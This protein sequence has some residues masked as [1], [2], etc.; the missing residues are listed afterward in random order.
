MKFC[1]IGVGGIGSRHVESL[2]RIGNA[3]VYCVDPVYRD[4]LSVEGASYFPSLEALPEN[5]DFDAVVISTSSKPRFDLFRIMCTRRPAMILLEKVAFTSQDDYQRAIDIADQYSVPVFINYIFRYADR[6]VAAIRKSR[7]WTI[8]GPNAGMCCN[9]GHFV[10]LYRYAFACAPI[11]LSVKRTSGVYAAKR[12]G[13]FDYAGISEF[14]ADEVGVLGTFDCSRDDGDYRL[15]TDCGERL[16]IRD[17]MPKVSD[18]TQRC[19]TDFLE[20]GGRL[21]SL[22]EDF[23]NF[24]LI[25]DQLAVSG[26]WDMLKPLPIT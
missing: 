15:E 18:T 3:T 12:K 24:L 26:G 19:I 1:V 23:E 6:I 22:R 13:Y 9:L 17:E 8:Y 5:I 2:L 11:R 21:P 20:G 10:D 7:T 25:R 14:S 16:L 4:W